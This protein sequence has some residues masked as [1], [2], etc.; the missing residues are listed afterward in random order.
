MAQRIAGVSPPGAPFHTARMVRDEQG[1]LTATHVIRT[2]E[3]V[4]F[5]FELA[6]IYSRFLAWLIDATLCA[7]LSAGIVFALSFLAIFA[8]GV[9]GFAIFLAVFLVNWGYFALAEAWTGGQTLGK[10][11]LGLR[12]VQVSGVRIDFLQ[13]ALRNLIR[14]FDNLPL[15]YAVGGGAALVSRSRRRLGDWVAGTVVVRERVRRLPAELG[16]GAQG[17]SAAGQVVRL[18]ERLRRATVPERELLLSAALRREELEV[19]ARLALFAELSRFLTERFGVEKPSH[20]SDEKLVLEAVAG[21]LQLEGA[22]PSR[23]AR[24]RR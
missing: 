19:P 23:A 8:A 12:V 6:G 17:A 22:A 20:L 18:H 7:V 3:L 16:L 1:F 5:Q 10:R 11:L 15:L 21:L 24:V 14:A 2:P 13:A 4:E 9:A